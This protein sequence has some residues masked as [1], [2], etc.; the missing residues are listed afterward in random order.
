MTSKFIKG[1]ISNK[2]LQ[3]STIRYLC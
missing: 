1:M 3:I 2:A